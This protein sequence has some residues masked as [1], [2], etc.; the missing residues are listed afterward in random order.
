MSIYW[1]SDQHFG[2][3]NIIKHTKRPFSTVEEMDAYMIKQWNSVVTEEDDVYHLGDISHKRCA[4]E[5]ANECIEQLNGRIHLILGNHETDNPT[6]VQFDSRMPIEGRLL[7]NPDFFHTINEGYMYLRIDGKLVVMSHYAPETWHDMSK[8]TWALHGHS[9]GK[10]TKK[11]RRLDVG[12]DTH[13]FRPWS[14]EEVQD[15]FDP[16]KKRKG[17]KAHVETAF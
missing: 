11:T 6:G 12:V 10:L 8:G 16:Q 14:W 13:D 17:G 3:E 15:H 4:P 2:H 9:H 5:R 7:I 1:S